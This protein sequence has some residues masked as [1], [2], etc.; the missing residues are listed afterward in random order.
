MLNDATPVADE[1]LKV[2]EGISF[3]GRVN[4]SEDGLLENVTASIRR[5]HQQLRPSQVP[6]YEEVALIGGGPSLADTLPELVELD[7]AGAKLVTVN[8]AYRWALEKHLK[9]T[10]QIVMDARPHNARFV[11]PFKPKCHYILASQCHPD[12]WDAVADYP[13]SYDPRTGV[14]DGGVWI[15]HAVTGGDPSIKAVLDDYYRQQWIGIGG[16][17]TVI[18]RA[19]GLM[20]VMWK[21][22]RIHLFGVDSCYMNGKGH[23]YEQPENERDRAMPFRVEPTGHPELARTFMA[24]PW[25]SKQSEDLCQLIRLHADNFRIHVHGDGMLAYMLKSAADAAVREGVGQ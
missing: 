23:A 17:T 14:Q 25:M 12:T 2:F 11:T 18:M 5:G 3:Q 1:A 19:I 24:A 7:R 9:P 6:S 10:A 21:V 20:S 16:G 15:F 22:R 4:V 13:D 8:G